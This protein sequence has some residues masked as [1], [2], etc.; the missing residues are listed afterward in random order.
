[1]ILKKDYFYVIDKSLIL[2]M[3]QIFKLV[4]WMDASI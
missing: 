2:K 3:L 4:K 1:M